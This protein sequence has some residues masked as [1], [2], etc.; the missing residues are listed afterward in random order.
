MRLP[1]TLLKA[2][3]EKAAAAGMTYQRFI[4]AALEDAVRGKE[5]MEVICRIFA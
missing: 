2:L 1:P 5:V 4:R 3:R